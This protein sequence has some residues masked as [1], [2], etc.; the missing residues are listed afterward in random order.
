ML[1]LVKYHGLG[2]D[3]LIVLDEV[4]VDAV[5]SSLAGPD[6]VGELARAL[7]DRHSGVGADG[8]LISRAAGSGADLRMELRNADGGRAETSGN[9]LRCFALAAVDAGL[10]PGPEILVETDAGVRRAELRERL[11]TG[12]GAVSVEMGTVRTTRSDPLAEAALP[13]SRALPWP[14]WSVDVGNPHLVLLAPSLKGIV[15][16]AVGPDL[17][18][19]RP[20][21]QNVEIVSY[22]PANAELSLL[23]WE[24]GAGVTLA[25]G[26]GSVAAAAA[27][28]SAGIC[29]AR[30]RVHNPGGVAEVS[31]SGVDPLA[32][33]AELAGAV[34]RVARIE[35][36]PE[37]LRESTRGVSRS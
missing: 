26:S 27:L 21:G 12:C 18:R 28:H 9:G 15:L 7:C 29:P 34:Q 31:L 37:D 1:E 23:V 24:R 5:A 35:V 32:V 36:D 16:D 19:R 13:G 10:V 8:L 22:T 25:C 20:G 33:V 11:G 3:F 4:L 2:N 14:A 6:P 30:V 17:E